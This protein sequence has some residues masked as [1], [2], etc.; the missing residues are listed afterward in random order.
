MILLEL[1]SPL[2]ESTWISGSVGLVE[3]LESR[4]PVTVKVGDNIK[5]L[6]NT[7][8]TIL[9]PVYGLPQPSVRW[10]KGGKPIGEG[11]TLNGTNLVLSSSN[12]VRHSGRYV[13]IAENRLDEARASSDVTYVGKRI[14]Q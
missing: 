7:Q 2:I 6:T 8:V 13:C 9:C 14:E 5:V 10:M 12:G 4:V 11:H 1:K 3:S